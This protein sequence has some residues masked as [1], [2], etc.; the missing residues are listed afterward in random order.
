MIFI[1]VGCIGEGKFIWFPMAFIPGYVSVE[2]YDWY[3]DK[4]LFGWLKNKKREIN[5]VVFKSVIIW[6]G[7]LWKIIT[8]S[9]I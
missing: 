4:K 8:I 1:P 6:V 5:R 3:W 7:K 9:S 2:G